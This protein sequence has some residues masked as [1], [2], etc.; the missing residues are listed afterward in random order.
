MKISELTTGQGNVDV[1]GNLSEVGEP[2][3]FT[4]FGRE[5]KVSNAILKD[6]SGSI[7]LTLWNEDVSKFNEGDTVKITNGYVNEFQGEPQL[8]AGKFGKMEKVGEGE[9]S[10]SDEPEAGK[11]S[12]SDETAETMAEDASEDA[13]V[14]EAVKEEAP[15]GTAEEQVEEASEE[16][17]E[18]AEESEEPEE[19]EESEEPEKKPEEKP[20]ESEAEESQE[21]F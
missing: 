15:E 9:V 14:E 6:D 10:E 2:K 7:K 4:K 20:E 16:L 21:D 1:E 5:L 3:V 12:L 19:S 8:T 17:E 13:A 18:A 11:A